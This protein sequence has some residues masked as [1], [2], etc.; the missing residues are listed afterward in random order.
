VCCSLR[1]AATLGPTTAFLLM[2]LPQDSHPHHHHEH[3]C[4]HDRPAR[5]AHASTRAP[6]PLGDTGAAAGACRPVCASRAAA[7]LSACTPA[8]VAAQ[9]QRPAH[10]GVCSKQQQWQRQRCSSWRGRG[11]Q[12]QQQQQQQ[13]PPERPAW[14]A[15]EVAARHAADAAGAAGARGSGRHCLWWAC[16]CARKKKTTPV[17]GPR[18]APSLRPHNTHA[19]TVGCCCAARTCGCQACSTRSTTQWPSC[20]CG[21]GFL[22]YQQVPRLSMATGGWRACAL[23]RSACMCIGARAQSP[24]CGGPCL[25]LSPS[26]QPGMGWAPVTQKAAEVFALVWA[27]SQVRFWGGGG[28]TGD[29]GSS[30]HS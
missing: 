20:W 23:A 11:R 8:A 21:S 29:R 6:V 15:A 7:P 9:L 1:H 2:A 30:S 12:Q 3:V 13:E 22:T 4:C 28:A 18:G 19:A 5:H 25:S 24:T 17:A 27:G 26:A 10:S 16:A 14:T